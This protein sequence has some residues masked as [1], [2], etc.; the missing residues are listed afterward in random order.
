VPGICLLARR[1]Q[2]TVSTW[3]LCRKQHQ[4]EMASRRG[5]SPTL[6]EQFH[7]GPLLCRDAIGGARVCDPC[8]RH[9]PLAIVFSA[10]PPRHLPLLLLTM[11]TL[12]LPDGPAPSGPARP[13]L[14]LR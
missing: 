10:H 12:P 13:C 6:P 7:M 4:F 3:G 14:R 11:T 5:R 9:F 2:I 8:M 1:A